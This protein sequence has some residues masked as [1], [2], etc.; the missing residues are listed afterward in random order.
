MHEPTPGHGT[1]VG[2]V[3]RALRISRPCIDAVANRILNMY[4]TYLF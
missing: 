3:Q 2:S 1:V 4:S